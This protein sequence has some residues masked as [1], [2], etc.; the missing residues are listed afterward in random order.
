MKIIFVHCGREHLGIE[1][2]SA[3]LKANGHETALAFDPGLFSKEDNVFSSLALE[4]F[5]SRKKSVIEAIIDYNADL[6]VFSVYTT[7][8]QWALDIAKKIRNKIKGKIVFG[9]IHATLMPEEVIKNDVV[10]FVVVGEGEYP[11]LELAANLAKGSFVRDIRNI[12][13]KENGSIVRNSMREPIQDLDL[14]PLP[15]KDLFAKHVR[16]KD[17]YMILTSRGCPFSC[18]YCCESFLN[19]IYQNKYF[20]RRSIH[21]VLNELRTMK[22]RYN[23]KEVMFFDSILFT[24][25]IWLQD[26]LAGF[27]KEIDVPFRC[28]GHVACF[29]EEI[30]NMLKEGG[31]YCID[32]GVQSFNQ[33]LR[34]NL[35]NRNETNSC[36][37]KAFY[38]CD[39]IKM[40]YD[41]DIMFGLPGEREEDFI[42]AVGVFLKHSFINRV[43]CYNLSYYPGL[44]IM[45]KAYKNNIL[46][47]DDIKRINS[48]LIN[49]WFH[50]DFLKNKEAKRMNL[51]FRNLFKIVALLPH[52]ITG[53][54][55]KNK[56]Y[57]IFYL[58]PQ[59]LVMI[60]QCLGGI[61]HKDY[62]FSIYFNNYLKHFMNLFFNKRRFS[63]NENKA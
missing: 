62:R 42:N 9:G 43:K 6:V 11:L 12:W 3:V 5:F 17:D 36:I 1:Y 20:R 10:D 60:F 28:T 31:C 35:L 61:L 34:N 25:K 4:K 40:R 47:N 24:D 30:A 52:W 48:G 53:K 32:F 15:D 46:N 23:F 51:N 27:K 8:Y 54:I 33:E 29:D 2:L 19:G 57:R 63:Y 38:L 49:D 39:K 26:L 45:E 58:M 50:S 14:L 41:I 37:D 56:T 16:F 21:S 7:T 55:I 13:L 59:F 44:S 22:K 18:S